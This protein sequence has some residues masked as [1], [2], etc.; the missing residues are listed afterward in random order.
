M[1][2]AEQCGHDGAPDRP[3]GTEHQHPLRLHPCSRHS[4][5]IE[6]ALPLPIFFAIEG[7]GALGGIENGETTCQVSPIALCSTFQPA[8]QSCNDGFGPFKRRDM[9]RARYLGIG[10]IRQQ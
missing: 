7:L 3:R 8:A 2:A 9:A 1:S 4:Q 6:R 10:R 5:T